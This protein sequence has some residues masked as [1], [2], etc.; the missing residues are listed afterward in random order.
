MQMS[1]NQDS[2]RPDGV[3]EINFK[4]VSNGQDLVLGEVY[5]A[6]SGRKFLVEKLKFFIS[7][8]VLVKADGSE[9]PLV[10][11]ALIDMAEDQLLKTGHNGGVYKQYNVPA[12][13][14]KGIKFGIGVK[15]SLN[16]IDPATQDENHPLGVVN[17]MNWNWTSGYRFIVYEGRVDSS[18][19]MNG[20]LVNHPNVWHT[21][22]DQLYR[23]V[24]YLKKEHNFA[25][26]E[27]EEYQ[28]KF[29]INV[30]QLLKGMDVINGNISHTMPVGSPEYFIAKKFTE[31]FV[32]KALLKIP[33]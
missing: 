22:A 29:E 31:N 13:L 14:Y 12:G 26:K 21:G 25:V 10:N 4:A 20:L 33:D 3:F 27:G 8:V 19:S 32:E 11:I 2:F 7:D 28:F 16:H 9:M 18:A 1:C 17:G 15:E 5:E 6:N 24:E 30:N 23:K